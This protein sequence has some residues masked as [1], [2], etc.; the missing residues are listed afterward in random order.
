MVLFLVSVF[1]CQFAQHLVLVLILNT[2]SK[3]TN[4]ELLTIL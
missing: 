2:I 1:N 4:N 3:Y